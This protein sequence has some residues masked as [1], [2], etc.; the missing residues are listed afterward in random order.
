MTNYAVYKDNTGDL[1]FDI[2]NYVYPEDLD[3]TK[4]QTAITPAIIML[5][6]TIIVPGS[7][8]RTRPVSSKLQRQTK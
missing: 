3:Y 7:S 2:V 5:T 4:G 8:I 1:E 6:I